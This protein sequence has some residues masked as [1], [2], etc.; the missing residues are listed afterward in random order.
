MSYIEKQLHIIS[1]HF[2]Y[3]PNQW[4][5]MLHVKSSS[6]GWVHVQNDPKGSFVYVPSQ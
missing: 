5:M 6:I 3:G 4:E 2:V 1:Y